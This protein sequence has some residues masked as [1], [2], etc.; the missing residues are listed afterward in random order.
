MQAV[1][2]TGIQGSGKSTFYKRFLFRTHV[3]IS[4]DLLRTRHREARFLDLCLD[5][6][7]RFAVDNTN[8]TAGDRRRYIV[9]ASR[10]GYE[11]I[12][13]YFTS[14]IDSALARNSSRQRRE[15]VAERGI[16]ATF[17]KLQPPTFEEGFSRIYTIGI[18]QN[19]DYLIESAG[20]NSVVPFPLFRMG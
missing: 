10:L 19:G 13:C 11:L 1:L 15:V 16:W 5:T 7:S 6:R 8:P 2:F 17:R 12:C 18:E 20:E 14:D 4:L 3:R 9:P